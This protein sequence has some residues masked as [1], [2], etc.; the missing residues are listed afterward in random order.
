MFKTKIVKVTDFDPGPGCERRLF[1]MKLSFWGYAMSK[2]GE[3]VDQTS[4]ENETKLWGKMLG[5][6]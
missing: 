4:G 1:R 3:N 6:E 2:F 5:V